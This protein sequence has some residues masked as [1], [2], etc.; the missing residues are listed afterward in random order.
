MHVFCVCANRVFIGNAYVSY[1]MAVAAWYVD[2]Q[3]DMSESKKKRNEHTQ[4]TWWSRPNPRHQ[5]YLEVWNSTRRVSTFT[6][7]SLD[8]VLDK[9]LPIPSP[10]AIIVARRWRTASSRVMNLLRVSSMQ[11]S[12]EN[13]EARCCLVALSSHAAAA[14]RQLVN[15]LV[16]YVAH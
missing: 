1:A 12:L 14:G 16:R 2:L 4:C 13:R 7:T 3:C 8:L 6:F 5:R 10:R 11:K 9:T 15:L